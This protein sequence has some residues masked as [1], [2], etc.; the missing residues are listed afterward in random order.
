MKN[1]NSLENQAK[2]LMA[3]NMHM[4]RHLR[5]L[6]QKQIADHLSKSSNAVSN[7]EL[8]NTSPSIDDLIGLCEI[9]K[10]TPNELLGWDD[11]PELQEYI[12]ASEGVAEKLEELKRQKKLIDAQIKEYSEKINR[13]K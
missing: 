11:C 9:L 5:G 3:Y 6:S 12:K 10:I 2:H 1:D 4:M 7:W 13:K 8:G